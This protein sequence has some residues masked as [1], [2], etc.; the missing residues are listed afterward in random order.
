[1]H[2]R[3]SELVRERAGL[4]DYLAYKEL[5]ALAL[6]MPNNQ[7]KHTVINRWVNTGAIIGW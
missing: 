4:V 6:C 3:V 5:V 2:R 7:L 1:M